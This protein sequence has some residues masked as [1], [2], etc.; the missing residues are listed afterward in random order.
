MEWRDPHIWADLIGYN[1]LV[2]ALLASA[3]LGVALI[4]VIVVMLIYYDPP[5]PD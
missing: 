4:L 1:H 5:T 2:V 3:V